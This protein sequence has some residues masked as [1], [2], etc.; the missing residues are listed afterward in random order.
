MKA[1]RFEVP[2]STPTVAR[3]AAITADG[4]NRRSFLGTAR[5]GRHGAVL[6]EL[7][8]AEGGR[9]PGAA[10]AA[11]AA[12]SGQAG[13]DLCDAQASAADELAVLGRHPD[14]EAEAEGSG[15]R[16]SWRS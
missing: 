6:A 8:G 15:S 12:A 9:G 4:V 5:P 16:A 13:A 10:A 7:G 11:A 1:V 14:Q 3:T 2:S